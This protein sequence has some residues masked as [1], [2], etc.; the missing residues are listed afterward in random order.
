MGALAAAPP[1]GGAGGEQALP[2]GGVAEWYLASQSG[3]K[4]Q[5]GRGRIRLAP[6]QKMRH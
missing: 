3:E 5:V 4:G 6:R 1:R 2:P